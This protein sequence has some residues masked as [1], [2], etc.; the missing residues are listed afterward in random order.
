MLNI[1]R[2]M[3]YFYLFYWIFR[4]FEEHK[5]AQTSFE[6][7]YSFQRLF[8]SLWQLRFPR[9]LTRPGAILQPFNPSRIPE[10]KRI[11]FFQQKS[12][13][14]IANCVEQKSK[15]RK[16]LVM[17]KILTSTDIKN[18]GITGPIIRASG[19]I[20]SSISSTSIPTRQSSQLLLKYAYT[21]DNNLLG[22][23]RVVYAELILALDR[24]SH[25]LKSYQI[26]TIDASTESS[27][28]EATFS[29]ST[30]LGE[31]YLTVNISENQVR[32]FNFIPPQMSN[33]TG[34]SKI[35]SSCPASLK[36][37]V[38]LFFDPEIAINFE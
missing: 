30:A 38:L 21:N 2:A 33:L 26:R 10:I 29:F 27:N 12:A 1:E 23:L 8:E 16:K 28:G 4:F 37:I 19:A 9:G 18:T 36:P 5:T 24:I 20:P 17:Q 14:K 15:I 7:F 13:W 22:I 35:L 31:S 11:I 25:L 34:F 32:Y 3:I 6:S